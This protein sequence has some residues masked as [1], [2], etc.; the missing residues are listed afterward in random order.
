MLTFECYYR[1]AF[2]NLFR[3]A[4]HFFGLSDQRIKELTK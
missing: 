1:Y 4:D 3:T 2:I